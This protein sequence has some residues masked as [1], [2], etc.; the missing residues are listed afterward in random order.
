MRLI[1]YAYD[2]SKSAWKMVR[3]CFVF[4]LIASFA[5]TGLYATDDELPP[6]SQEVGDSLT[7]IMD[8]L[9]AA[10]VT[11]STNS[12]ITLSNC[13]VSIG[14][15][16]K[17][18]LRVA[19]FLADP[20]EYVE[21]LAPSAEGT[22]FLSTFLSFLSNAMEDPLVSAVYMAMVSRGY[23]NGDYL[24]SGSITFSYPE[25]ATFDDVME[26]WTSRQNTGKSI[27][28][29]VEMGVYGTKMVRPIYVA[30][31]FTMQVNDDGE[32]VVRSNGEYK[33]NS[34]T[35]VNGEFRF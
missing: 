1:V 3:R 16:S 26:V 11:S 30:G 29:T 35:F 27:E 2:I 9:S 24:L 22:S 33:I 25:G 18:P 12:N 23:A 19:F 13:T 10:I 31:S 21:A 4:F 34:F 14:Q 20:A 5:F 7:V 6:T 32:I 8:C 15:T 28:L 17:L